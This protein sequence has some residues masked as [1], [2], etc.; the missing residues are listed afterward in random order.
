MSS[1]LN[2]LPFIQARRIAALVFVVPMILIT[3]WAAL[4]IHGSF[5]LVAAIAAGGFIGSFVIDGFLL[6]ANLA[7][8]LRLI[9]LLTT[10]AFSAAIASAVIIYA[11]SSAT[12]F[13]CLSGCSDAR[14]VQVNSEALGSAG[15]LSLIAI[16]LF[17]APSLSLLRHLR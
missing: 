4:T 11:W 3:I 17:L 15:I 8:R 7:D 13:V 9:R 2:R 16:L 6:H 1:Q 12:T 5:A 14:I 10:Q